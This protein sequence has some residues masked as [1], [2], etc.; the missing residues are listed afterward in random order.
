MEAR[1]EY[2]TRIFDP[3]TETGRRD[4]PKGMAHWAGTGP[5][6]TTCRFCARFEANKRGH[7]GYCTKYRELMP[8]VKRLVKFD[9]DTPSCRYYEYKQDAD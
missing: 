6:G 9:R 5:P 1:S 3:V 4:T 8:K 2:L 7:R